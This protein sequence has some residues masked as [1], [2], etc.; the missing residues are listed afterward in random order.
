M[1]VELIKR[2]ATA[3]IYGV[4]DAGGRPVGEVVRT[5]TGR[6]TGTEYYRLTSRYSRPQIRRFYRE[7]LFPKFELEGA[8]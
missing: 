1:K 3:S 5:W 8:K 7:A 6:D 2:T 4:Y